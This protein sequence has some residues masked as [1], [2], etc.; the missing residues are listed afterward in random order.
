MLHSAICR[1]FLPVNFA[2]RFVSASITHLISR[3]FFY[4]LQREEYRNL[5]DKCAYFY[6]SFQICMSHVRSSAV[7]YREQLSIVIYSWRIGLLINM[8]IRFHFIPLYE[9]KILI[10]VMF[11]LIALSTWWLVQGNILGY[12]YRVWAWNR[13]LGLWPSGAFFP[14]SCWNAGLSIYSYSSQG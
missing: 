3:F 5:Q 2:S 1:V 9:V 6:V 7:R 12:F 8:S 4:Q 14:S 11:L 13:H 10:Y